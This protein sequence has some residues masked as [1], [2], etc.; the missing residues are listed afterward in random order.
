LNLTDGLTHDLALYFLDWGTT[1]RVEQVTISNAATGAVLDSETVS[2]FHSGVYL[3]WMVSGQVLI[4]I[5]RTAGINAVLSGLFL[6]PPV[7]AVFLAQNTTTEGNWIG[8]YGSSGYT[9]V[10]GATNLPTTVTIAPA[11]A[12]THIWETSTTDN[13]A[14]ENP[15]GTGRSAAAW[16]SPTSFTVDVNV[17]GAA[18]EDVAVYALDWGYANRTEQIQISNA[19]TGTVLDTEVISNFGTGVYLQWLVAG[20]VVIK[21]TQI[22]GINA[23]LTGVFLDT[24]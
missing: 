15:G 14:L 18:P 10:G 3:Q 6:D 2:S 12:S 24:P 9:I 21:V 19:A 5:T 1:T 16:Y 13:R 4:T 20:N 17:R 23:V 22:A 11:G 7:S 8:H